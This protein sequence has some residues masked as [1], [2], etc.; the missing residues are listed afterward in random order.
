MKGNFKTIITGTKLVLVDFYA[1][2]C[3]PCKTQ[4]PIIS[5]LS[6][7][8]GNV[9][10][11]IKIDIDKNPN[12]AQQYQIKGVPTLILFKNGNVVWRQSGVQSKMQL[13]QLINEFKN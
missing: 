10:R 4:G 9:V 5:E 11:I 8:V 2:W 7:E 3:G 1:D 12:I 13:M 6:K